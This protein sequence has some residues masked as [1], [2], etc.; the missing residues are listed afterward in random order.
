MGLHL[1][2]V[3][4]HRQSLG[5]RGIKEF[6]QNGG[7]IG[8]S[9]ESDWVLP[10]GQR[11]LSSRHASVDYRS[12]SYYIIDTSTNGVYINGAERPVGRG[13]PQRIF[14]G[15]RIRIGDYEILVSIDEVDSTREQMN[16]LLH[17]DPVDLKQRVDAPDPTGVDLVDAY[18]ITGVGIEMLLDE[19]E[20]NTLSPLSYK[21]KT[22]EL[23]LEDEPATPP[24][25]AAPEL[26]STAVKA[27]SARQQIK[28][29][30]AA[31]KAEAAARKAKAKRSRSATARK[32]APA[33]KNPAE[34][35]TEP[36]DAAESKAAATKAAA[37]RP[38][39]PKATTPR[40]ATHGAAAGKS[41][42]ASKSGSAEAASAKS[43]GGSGALEAFF[44][45]VGL[46]PRK[47]DDEQAEQ[48][49]LRLGQLVRE[50]IVGVTENLHLRAA[51]KASLRQ[52]NTTIQRRSNN[53]LK[54]TA[55]VD[56]ALEHLLFKQSS[57]YLDTVAAAREA[58]DDIKI[59]QQVMFKSVQLAL[60]SYME[61]LDPDQLEDKFSNGRRGTIMGAAS[62]LKY[63]DMYR[64]LYLVVGQGAS[65][66]MPQM[67][68]D[69]LARAYEKEIV[70]AEEAQA[71][72]RE[73][74][75]IVV[76]VG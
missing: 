27:A 5:E 38:T 57:E 52:S 74:P 13:N 7:T 44:R 11:F 39:Q 25:T 20:A 17:V 33:E 46:E 15:D 21:F 31:A 14:S 37:P 67:F 55:S 51:Q 2:V 9:L 45:G 10:D 54:F 18:E 73:E 56:D 47:L 30:A 58:F 68:L 61:K 53:A 36:K 63:W 22:D 71:S 34:K 12:G 62:R 69:E 28:A 32:N 43:P 48:T 59:H 60:S 42:T 65:G 75:S 6:G 19:D 8:R 70:R 50:M 24:S 16:D 4:R 66:E 72:Q 64:D 40:A 1:Q 49:M 35:N 29:A 23:T 41:A 3:S 76:S 26:E